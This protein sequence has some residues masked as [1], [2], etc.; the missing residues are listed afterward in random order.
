M[1]KQYRIKRSEIMKNAWASYR[2]SQLNAARYGK[3]EHKSFSECLKLAWAAYKRDIE[4]EETNLDF[5]SL[6]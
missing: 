3:E 5:S 6:M 2:K 4:T 1:S